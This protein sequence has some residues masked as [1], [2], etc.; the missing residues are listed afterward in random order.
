[1]NNSLNERRITAPV[2][3][4]GG[5]IMGCATAYYLAKCGVKA[6]LLEKSTIATEASGR[7]AGGV[8]AQCRDRRERTLAMASIDLWQGLE[9]EL[10]MGVEYGQAGNIRLASSEERLAQL[11]EE[12]EEELADG[13]QVELWDR[14]TLRQRAPYLGSGFVGAKYCA[15]DGMANPTR[16]TAAFA[17]AAQQHGATVLTNTEVAEIVVEAGQISAVRARQQYGDLL[18]DTSQVLHA[19][20][21]WTAALSRDLGITIPLRPIRLA[22]GAT[23]PVADPFPSFLSSHDLGIAARPTPNG[24]I[25][26]SGF[27]DPEPTFSKDVSA[28]ALADLRAIDEMVPAYRGISFVHAWAG[29]LNVTPDEA[30]VLGAVDGLDGYLLATGFSGHG[31]C[32]GPIMGKLMAEWIVEGKPSIALE[33]FRLSR[34][35][36]AQLAWEETAGSSVIAGQLAR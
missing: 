27:G 2:V 3:I 29:L 9:A 4:I 26:V 20:G 12:G 33:D 14:D 13:L 5:G 22:I 7:N 18:I 24:Q 31:F 23:A 10:G 19:A 11:V 16:A 1:M 36:E 28:N 25:Y 35:T 15:L 30:P 32:L 34:F 21:P 6:V 17:W 8:R